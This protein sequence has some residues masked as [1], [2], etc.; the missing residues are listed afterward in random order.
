MKVCFR[1]RRAVRFAWSCTRCR[2]PFN[3]CSGAF[4]DDSNGLGVNDRIE[5][6][7]TLV[8]GDTYPLYVGSINVGEER[9]RG[10]GR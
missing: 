9:N 10:R 2:C 8:R 3:Q 7:S 1:R 6:E 5:G 4:G